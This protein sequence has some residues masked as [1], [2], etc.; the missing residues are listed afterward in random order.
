M[1]ITFNSVFWGNVLKNPKSL[2]VTGLANSKKLFDVKYL[3]ELHFLE[4]FQLKIFFGN[5][6]ANYQ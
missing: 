3:N 4:L 6:F 5:L 1:K 2:I